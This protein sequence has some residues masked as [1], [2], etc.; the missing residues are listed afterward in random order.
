MGVDY[1]VWTIPQLRTFRPDAEQ[2]ANLANALRESGWV[3]KSEFVPRS[4]QISELL[5][6]NSDFGEKP[7]WAKE[8]DPEQFTPGWVAFHSQRELVIDWW[9]NNMIE[10]GVQYPFVFDP[11]PDSGPPYFGISL[12]QGEEFFYATDE[13]VM[14][15][16]EDAT[17][18]ACG[19]QLAWDSYSKG[20]PA[21]TP[22]QRIHPK[23]PKCGRSFD[24]SDIACDVLDG[25][26][27]EPTPLAGGLTFQFALVVHCHKY[28]PREEEAQ[29]RF[30]LREDFL[31][32]WRTHVGVPFEQVVTIG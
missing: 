12:L 1:T 31:D 28:W 16:E 27:G 26:T 5:P 29:R 25:W 15:F 21:R 14:A 2:F 13:N 18:C 3:P 10:A 6:G 20:A 24:P 11:Y 32:L 30:K 17:R 8:I 9:V 7:G 22:S 23:C 19:E 4:L